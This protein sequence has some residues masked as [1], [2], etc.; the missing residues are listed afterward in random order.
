M[1]GACWKHTTGMVQPSWCKCVSLQ[2][3]WWKSW[4]DLFF[5]HSFGQSILAIWPLR[6]CGDWFLYTPVTV[7]TYCGWYIQQAHKH[8][9][10][11]LT[12]LSEDIHLPQTELWFLWWQSSRKLSCLVYVATDGSPSISLSFLLTSSHNGPVSSLDI[13]VSLTSRMPVVYHTY[14]HIPPAAF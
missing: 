4:R 5:L 2:H 1:N 6:T 13:F 9:Q 7:K 3:S 12:L 8:T 10:N 11:L 14:T